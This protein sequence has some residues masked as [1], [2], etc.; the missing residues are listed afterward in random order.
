LPVTM[1]KAMC[2]NELQPPAI[3]IT[4]VT[5]G[6]G[7]AMIEDFVRAGHKVLGCA[8]TKPD[9]ED[10]ARAYPGHDFQTVDVASDAQ[11]K[12]WAGRLLLAYGPPDFLLNNAA[13]INSKASLWEVEDRDFSEEIDINIKGVVNVI[14]HF[15]PAMIGRR[16]GV[17]VNFSSR[18]GKSFE[19]QM[20]PYC[21]S[22]WAVVALT[23]A[24]AQ[25]LRP[26]G[27]AA[28]ALNPGI[29]RTGMLRKYL[30]GR[31]G[32]DMSR[33]ISAEEWAKVAVPFILNLNLK[34]TGKLRNVFNSKFSTSQNLGTK[35][36]RT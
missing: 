29:V 36:G 22:K 4:G 7:R 16:R 2:P 17:I 35:G 28:V 6:L 3:V 27:V 26:E 30:N 24:L 14:R 10:L 12:A 32:S 13:I 11:V 34:D 8:R 9:I 1:S 15:V 18:W 20:A 23:L 19:K 5:R 31:A 21:A 25:E 33:Y